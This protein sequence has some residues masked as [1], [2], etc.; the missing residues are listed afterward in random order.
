MLTASVNHAP[1]STAIPLAN[2]SRKELVNYYN[3]YR[4]SIRI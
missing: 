1:T 3:L 4:R 2:G